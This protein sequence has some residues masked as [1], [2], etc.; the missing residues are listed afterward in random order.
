MHRGLMKGLICNIWGVGVSGRRSQLKDYAKQERVD[1]IGLHEMIKHDFSQPRIWG[2]FVWNWLP[3]VGCSGGLLL[4]SGTI[5]LR[6]GNRGTAPS[7]VLS[8]YN[9]IAT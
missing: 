6:S 2:Q 3:A 7:S 1:M 4:G 8:F 9:I 5:V